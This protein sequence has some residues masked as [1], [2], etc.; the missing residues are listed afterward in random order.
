MEQYL[1]NPIVIGAISSIVVGIVYFIDTKVNKEEL[2]N[3]KLIKMALLG[4]SIGIL[5]SFLFSFASNTTFK[6]DQDILTGT[7]NF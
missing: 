3:N 7:P 4:L 6:V 5:N 1:N 2:D